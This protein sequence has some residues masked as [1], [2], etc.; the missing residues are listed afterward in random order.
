MSTRASQRR[1]PSSSSI[2]I[3]DDTI[4]SAPEVALEGVALDDNPDVNAGTT[5]WGDSLGEGWTCN[6]LDMGLQPVGDND[7][8]T[9]PGHGLAQINCWTLDR[10]H[11]SR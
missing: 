9:G 4:I 10:Q 1:W 8:E 6:I 2:S 11:H 5:S 3:Y 7:A